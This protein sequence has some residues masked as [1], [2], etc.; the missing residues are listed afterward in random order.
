MGFFFNVYISLVLILG[1]KADILLVNVV[2]TYL[3]LRPI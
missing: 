1:P 3:V 2:G